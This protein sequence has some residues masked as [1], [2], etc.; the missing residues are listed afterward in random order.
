MII[1]I[2]E[3]I[4]KHTHKSTTHSKF[5]YLQIDNLFSE[6]L[7]FIYRCFPKVLIFCTVYPTR[8]KINSTFE[9]K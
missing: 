4:A 8:I 5:L 7:V 9:T 6:K 3:P 1:I 2:T